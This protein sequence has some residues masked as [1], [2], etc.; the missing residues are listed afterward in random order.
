[1]IVT[2]V[3]YVGH[4]DPGACKVQALKNFFCVLNEG[5]NDVT[6]LVTVK[7]GL[8]YTTFESESSQSFDTTQLLEFA[9]SEG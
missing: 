4:H 3:A 8:V 9:Q 1:M 2:V 6:G 5:S 7:A